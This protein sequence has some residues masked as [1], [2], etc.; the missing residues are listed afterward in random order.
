MT[1]QEGKN[2]FFFYY[3]TLHYNANLYSM[4]G[5]KKE[6]STDDSSLQFAVNLSAATMKLNSTASE[7]EKGIIDE[8]P[9][10]TLI[11]S[12]YFSLYC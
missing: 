7:G 5:R 12:F 9:W 4:K 1:F 10:S 2:D 3:F 11:G 8:Q 6:I